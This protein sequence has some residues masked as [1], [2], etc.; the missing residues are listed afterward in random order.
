M[1][2]LRICLLLLTVASLGLFAGRNTE[3][4][5]KKDDANAKDMKLSVDVKVGAQSH[6]KTKVTLMYSAKSDRPMSAFSGGKEVMVTKVVKDGMVTASFEI[7]PNTID[8]SHVH[9]IRTKVGSSSGGGPQ[10]RIRCGDLETLVVPLKAF[11]A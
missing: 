3:I 11:N 5:I 8:Q 4:I 2:Y 1:T 10:E 7:D 6:E 9:F